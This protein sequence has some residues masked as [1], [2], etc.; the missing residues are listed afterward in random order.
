MKK[1][2]NKIV[3]LLLVFT[4]LLSLVPINVSAVGS[5]ETTS[6]GA[7]LAEFTV[8]KVKG[9]NN[10]EVTIEVRVS[11]NSQIASAG[12]ELLFDSSKLLVQDYRAGEVFSK[13]MTAI[14]GNI[15]DKVIV[16]YVSMEPVVDEGT[17]FSV[18]F[19]VTSEDFNEKLDLNI[20][21]T[22]LTDI[23]GENL[24]STSESGSVE[25]VDLLYGDVDFNNKVSASDAL[26]ILSY[27]TEEIEF[28]TEAEKAADV[29]GD[30]K[31][32]VTD[33][34]QVLYYSAEMLDDFYI[35]T[36]QAPQNVNISEL[37]EYEFTISWDSM[38]YVLGYNVYFNGEKINN[39]LLTTNSVTIGGDNGDLSISPRI[40][41][42]IDHNTEYTIEI[43]AI[44]SLKE[45]EKSEL[46]NVKTKRAYSYVTFKDWD[47][48]IIGK[49]QRVLYGQ[50]AIVPNNP[51]REGYVFTG[52]D[53]DTTNI[54]EDVVITAQYEV[55]RYDY[56]FYDYNGEELYRQNVIH[57]GTATPPENPKRKGYTFAG[58]YTSAEGG[59][60]VTDFSDV[61]EEKAVYANYTINTYTVTF[62]SNGGSEVGS[63]N[64]DYQSTISKPS[65]PTKL[66][67]GFAG[68]YKESSLSNEWNFSKD[69]LDD[70]TT[71]YA[72]WNPVTIT[73]DK[74]NLTFN[75][76]GATGQLNATISGGTDSITWSSSN[77]AIAVVNSN[78][79]VTAKG[80]GT[81]TIYIQGTS[82][83][84]RPVCMVT[85]NASKTAWV[86]NTGNVNLTIRS[87]GTTASSV[88]G[89]LKE[90][91]EIT[92]YGNLQNAGVS[93][94][95][96][97]YQISSASGNGWVSANYVTFTK[98]S[99]PQISG[100]L[101]QKISAMRTKF[102][103]GAYWNTG[104]PDTYSWNADKCGKYNC[105]CTCYEKSWQCMGFARKI[106]HDIYGFS[107]TDS[108]RSVSYDNVGFN[109]VQVGDYIHYYGTGTD[110]YWG[111]KAFVI[112]KG[113]NYIAVA[114]AN[115]P[116]YCKIRWDRKIYSGDITKISRI[117]RPR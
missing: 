43:T 32:T 37:G 86:C 40:H 11:E 20:H 38:R 14:N 12:I 83:E 102:P 84:R 87:Q 4:F 95:T 76:I 68:W 7:T 75:T 51:V 109:S 10:K 113:S 24:K 41:N 42:Y 23:N 69:K 77:S 3:S 33:A 96:G 105:C 45:S 16:S 94:Q 52:W 49:K 115:C 60:Q 59:T 36:L 112:E 73:I 106:Y 27:C 61:K 46:L 64:A 56:I 8:T 66:G 81:A 71:L 79:L 53:K 9:I 82:S 108:S 63:V 17:I 74:S 89:Y 30:D 103:N 117:T 97:W 1:A 25:I 100:T 55:A 104:N 111:H 90:G 107:Q 15:S 35:Y 65:N 34:L 39:D 88:V 78:G 19:L 58:W 116:G 110:S 48:S 92:V 72:K 2:K 6:D 47:G 28:S 62:N 91:T 57:G 98:P 114:E 21:V 13:G 93:G 54:I 44:N 22:E 70:D 31:I 50:D 5:S 80:H 101:A 67:Y 85:V 99:I 26:Q 18:D 29:N